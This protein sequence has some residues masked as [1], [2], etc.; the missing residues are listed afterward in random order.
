MTEGADGM[1]F[2]RA[3]KNSLPASFTFPLDR[4]RGAVADLRAVA[5][6]FTPVAKAALSATLPPPP[7]RITVVLWSGAE[8]NERNIRLARTRT[9]Y[10]EAHGDVAAALTA[11][12]AG[13]NE[14]ARSTFYNHL[15]ALDVEDPD[16]RASVLLSNPTGNMDGMRKVRTHRKSRGKVR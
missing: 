15:N 9:A 1:G 2:L 8:H 6:T 13:G 11:L 16:W 3:G 14:I 4:I 5:P 12:K 10:L 7:D